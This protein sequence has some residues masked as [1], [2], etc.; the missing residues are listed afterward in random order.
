MSLTLWSRIGLIAAV[1]LYVPLVS[2]AAL[3]TGGDSGG[4]EKAKDQDACKSG[5]VETSKGK[6]TGGGIQYDN[7]IT[8][9]KNKV[10]IRCAP[11]PEVAGAVGGVYFCDLEGKCKFFFK[12]SQEG[13]NLL[14]LYDAAQATAVPRYGGQI[15]E[16][17]SRDV[18]AHM[19]N[20]SQ[21]KAIDSMIGKQ[22][23]PKF[24]ETADYSTFLGLAANYSAPDNLL[25]T[26][27]NSYHEAVEQAIEAMAQPASVP[28]AP[29]PYS[30]L[31]I[32]ID[33]SIQRDWTKPNIV[34]FLTP[35]QNAEVMNELYWRQ[36]YDYNANQRVQNTFEDLLRPPPVAPVLASSPPENS[37]SPSWFTR[38]YDSFIKLLFGK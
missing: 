7:K 5:S 37:H 6:V 27:K 26:P 35:W 9:T 11:I 23:F 36:K 21:M 38:T 30:D 16:A 34:N 12:D 18:L 8:I 28:V 10:Y 15:I 4:K 2:F 17:D 29:D 14:E 31:P 24:G 3:D 22:T 25:T 32:N 13:K 19:L 1:A 20:D 33:P